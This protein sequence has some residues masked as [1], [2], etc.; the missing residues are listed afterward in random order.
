MKNKNIVYGGLIVVAV[1]VIVLVYMNVSNAL[2]TDAN[3][4]NDV[5]ISTTT[6]HKVVSS[7]TLKKQSNSYLGRD[8]VY[9]VQYTDNGF[10][11]KVLQIPKGKSIRFINVSSSGMRVYTD[12]TGD[13]K[14]SGLNESATLGKGGTYTFSFIIGGLWMYYNQVK[15]VHSANI[16]VY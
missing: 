9:V 8:G 2:L 7:E 12:I 13:Q 11:P 16:I 1:I 14:F 6:Q 15:P 5:N 3:N 10:V 4:T